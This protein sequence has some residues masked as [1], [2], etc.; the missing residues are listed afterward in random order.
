MNKRKLNESCRG[1]LVQF[2]NC[3]ILYRGT[4]II[5]DLLVR[6]GVICNP[7]KI[8]FE[9]RITSDVKIDCKNLI[10]APGLID[11]QINGGFG[12]DFSSNLNQLE[13]ALDVVS[14]GILEHGVTSYCPTLVTSP[15][16]VY[17]QALPKICRR[18]GGKHG[19]EILGAHVEGPFI[20]PLKKGAHNEKYIKNSLNAGSNSVIDIYGS[21]DNIS[22]VTIAPEIEGILETI[23]HFL[24]HN[25][26]VSIGHS[27]ADLV[28]GEESV[29]RGATFITHLFNAMSSFHHRD[30]GL[31]GV[32]TSNT[33][34]RPAF[35]GVIADGI[36]THPTALRI[37]HRAHPKGIVLVTDAISAMGLPPGRHMLGTMSVNIEKNRVTLDGT[38]TLAGS[39]VTMDRCLRHFRK[40]AACSTVEALE[41]ATLHPAQLLGITDKK[42]TL[43][44][45]TDADL[46]VLD[47]EFN[48]HATLIAGQPAYVNNN[49]DMNHLNSVL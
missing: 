13:E 18:K 29:R 39:I 20:N 22:M 41:A 1:R 16:E 23:P 32:L 49:G 6:D 2:V 48:I 21:L 36:H 7:E 44:Y 5:E 34:P 10:I 42:G 12:Y 30:P 3:R 8:F 26:V 47:D 25:V 11:V 19:A 9:E 45:N 37:S 4:L 38:N 35:Y 17:R 43:E 24:K 31:L 27:I 33:I 28:C 46:V 15:T 40:A 14:K